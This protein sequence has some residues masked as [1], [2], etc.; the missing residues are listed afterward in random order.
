MFILVDGLPVDVVP[1]TDSSV[2]RG[3]GCFEA[4]RSYG[5]RLFAIEE[6][7]ERLERS[8]AMLQ[9]ALPPRERL[10]TW[11]KAAAVAG[12]D[13]IVRLVVTRGPAVPGVDGSGHAVV[14][15][16]QVPEVPEDLQLMP[17][18]APW[19]SAGRES[20]LAGAK[21]ISYAPNLAAARSA[22]A[23]GFHDALLL[24][25]D[26]TV[27]EG[28]TF[29]VAWVIDGVL[30]TPALDLR[31]LESITRRHVLALARDAGYQVVEGRFGLGRVL[32][33][34]EM[35]VFSTVKEV[36]AVARLGERDFSPGPVTKSLKDRFLA[37][38][39]ASIHP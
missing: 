2:I 25:D 3:D 6:H 11:C 16:H 17:L 29:A 22:V 18:R 38:V 9:L 12:G 23:A 31:I 30:E 24:A 10:A 28:P 35:M 21:T 19:H 7:L 26:L 8:A 1:V 27:L 34:D 15:H 32:G 20:A 36:T 14:I 5:G 33:A 13:G 4:A 37:H 39:E